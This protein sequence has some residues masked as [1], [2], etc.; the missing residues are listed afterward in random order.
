MKLYSTYYF[1]DLHTEIA[2]YKYDLVENKNN[3]YKYTR[4]RAFYLKLH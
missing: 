4:P 3:N 2:Q 1:G